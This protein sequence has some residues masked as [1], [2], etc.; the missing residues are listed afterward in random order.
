MIRLRFVLI[1]GAALLF[2]GM[3][4]VVMFAYTRQVKVVNIAEWSSANRELRLAATMP[5]CSC[6]ALT[7]ATPTRTRR[8]TR[9]VRRLLALRLESE[10]L[11]EDYGDIALVAR[12]AGAPDAP[13]IKNLSSAESQWSFAFDWAGSELG[14]YYSV[15]AYR[16]RDGTRKQLVGRPLD[17]DML[18]DIDA[19]ESRTCEWL[20]CS[21]GDLLMNQALGDQVGQN[22]V[23]AA[24]T[25]VRVVRDGRVIEAQ[26]TGKSRGAPGDC[27]CML[28]EVFN[29]PV[30]LSA[31]LNGANR[32]EL[33]FNFD[34]SQPDQR[35]RVLIPFDFAGRSGEDYYVI[36]ALAPTVVVSQQTGQRF[37]LGPGAGQIQE[38][39]RALTEQ[40]TERQIEDYVRVL[41]QLDGMRCESDAARFVLSKDSGPPSAAQVTTDTAQAMQPATTAAQPQ[42]PAAPQATQPA[43]QS[44]LPSMSAAR[45]LSIISCPYEIENIKGRIEGSM[46]LTAVATLETPAASASSNV[47]P[48]TK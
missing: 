24:F 4:G 13:A 3:V 26:A 16:T 39:T 45:S 10:A 21:F 42:Q 43:P 22:T 5:M 19:S 47:D 17:L 31:T 48:G 44:T 14:D 46:K 6:L 36:S 34:P 9:A 32:G 11:H 37:N 20:T 40:F 2:M 18:F 12:R 33:V 41:G 25:G 35:A 29:A 30:K 23:A 15:Q 28:L 7:K 8:M 1:L 27:G 38:T